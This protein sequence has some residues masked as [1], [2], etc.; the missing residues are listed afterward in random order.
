MKIKLTHVAI[1]GLA[2]LAACNAIAQIP[3]YYNPFSGDTVKIANTSGGYVDANWRQAVQV[4]GDCAAASPTVSSG[5]GTNAAVVKAT[6][7]CAFE[8][9]S[10]TA[11]VNG[12]VG[13][14]GTL[15]NGTAVDGWYCSAVDITTS[16]AIVQTAKEIA[17]TAN[18]A[19]I[20]DFT[21]TGV[22]GNWTAND[23]ITGLCKPY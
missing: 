13:L 9:N 4:S 12:V 17:T 6:G 14:P 11:S 20:E 5:F 19:T 15:A 21:N 10:G 1:I 8:I 18:T 2:G 16:N 7:G 22:A 23:I 3:S